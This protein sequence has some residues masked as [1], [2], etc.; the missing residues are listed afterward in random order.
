VSFFFSNF[1]NDHD[2]KNMWKNAGGR[3][4]A[5]SKREFHH[6]RFFVRIRYLRENLKVSL[7]RLTKRIRS[8]FN[9]FLNRW[10]HGKTVSKWRRK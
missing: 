6:G 10:N 8:G 3:E 7:R 2:E 9:R 4:G 5:G 1:P